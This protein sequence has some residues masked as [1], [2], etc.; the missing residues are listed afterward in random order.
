MK[1]KVIVCYIAASVLAL[2]ACGSQK[3]KTLG[4]LK[5]KPVEEEV[6]DVAEMDH[7][8]VRNEYEE[9]LN[10]FE[11]KQLK[12]QIERRI[13]DVYM[14]EGA[15]NQ[16]ESEQPSSYYVDAIKAYRNIIEKYPNAPDNAEVLYQ[17]SKAY[18]MEGQ[19]DE[20]M[21]MLLELTS[22]HPAYPNNAEAYFRMGDIYYSRG[23]YKA[24]EQSYKATIQRD[25]NG[26]FVLNAHYMM[27]WAQYKQ[28]SFRTAA[29]SFAYVIDLLLGTAED[30]E[31]LSVSERPMVEDSI[32]SLSLSLDKIGGAAGMVSMPDFQKKPF[33]WLVYSHLGD[34]YLE[35]ELYEQSA[36]TFR[37]Y[38]V[39]NPS[40]L[41]AP[42][43]HNRLI[44]TYTTGSFPRQALLEKNKFVDNYGIHSS[45]YKNIGIDETAIA[46]LNVY[47]DEL[48]RH[49]YSE[50]LRYQ[51][52]LAELDKVKNLSEK[53]HEKKH[54]TL[55]SN[56]LNAF[57]NAARFYGEFVETFPQDDN[58][59]EAYF[60]QAEAYFFA[61]DY[62]AAIPGYERV[63]Y[64]PFGTSAEEHAADA[65]YAAIIAYQHHIDGLG[66]QGGSEKKIAQA[67]TQ[68]QLQAVDSMLRFAQTFHADERA[69]T[70]LTNTAEYLFS[71]NQYERAIEITSNLIAQNAELDKHLKKTAHGIMAHSYFK[72]EDYAN[73]R[74]HYAN[75]RALVARESEEYEAISE[76]LASTS[77][78]YSE[79][80][81][82]TN[83]VDLA[84]EELLAIK[85]RTP[86]SP[87]RVIAQYDAVSLLLDKSRWS[88]AIVELEELIALFPEHKLAA[89][90]PRKLAFAQRSNEQWIAAATSYLALYK[91]DQDEDVQREALFAA[92]QMYESNKDYEQAITYFKRYAR[93]YEQPFNTRM[94][95]RYR[96]AMNYE[97]L[98]ETKKRLFW[99][100]RIIEGDSKGGEQR[101]DRSRWLAAWAHI[102]YGDF[103]TVDF[104]KQR[105]RLPLPASLAKKQE[106]LKLASA[107]YEKAAD[108]G[109]LELVCE[110]GYKLAG[111]YEHLA[112]AINNAP[113]PK[114]LSSDD[115]TR[116]RSILA[117]QAQPLM[118]VTSDMHLANAE[119]A[120][121]GDFN[122]W[123]EKSFVKLSELIPERFDKHELIVSYGDGIR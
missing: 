55:S 51:K 13:A 93:Q 104:E 116:Y 120:W 123:I 70:V 36:E 65:G 17:L 44:N 59:D 21:S 42:W 105:L 9:L 20:A 29:S 25:A 118:A 67:Q 66:A 4:G 37:Q 119:R 68:W 18:D 61:E 50:G 88:S 3:P 58:V 47:L 113:A 53:T 121:E 30:L 27:G 39:E 100:R 99:L 60:L 89:E 23:N 22:R 109:F 107:R 16:Q 84:I 46:S 12:E 98:G 81:L 6:I 74:D 69:P 112:G 108:F 28:A 110:S 114:G 72:L 103:H 78:K 43:F 106:L 49:N 48:A 63:A 19:Q 75:E 85:Q 97:Q 80:L 8:S 40:S 62:D 45:Y 95:A 79:V 2:S 15:H 71:L 76:R 101:T 56:K 11:D 102:Q 38:L 111:L 10:L 31:G 115:L 7:E 35:K 91:N 87:V 94:E 54:K 77:Y 5:Y 52:E 1:K 24:A 57:E 73:A 26:R 92:A 83:Q 86:D 41:R 96:L 32:H 33:I 34:F 82:S 117:Q 90:F 64:Q 122:E 14:M